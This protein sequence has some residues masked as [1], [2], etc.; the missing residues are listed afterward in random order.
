MGFVLVAPV[1]AMFLIVNRPA[2]EQLSPWH[3]GSTLFG[4]T[5]AGGLVGLRTRSL[6]RNNWQ[7]QATNWRFVTAALVI[8]GALAVAMY[9]A[10][11]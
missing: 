2:A 9:V 3:I 6:S 1:Y 5:L 4:A 10:W 7:D 11:W 8:G